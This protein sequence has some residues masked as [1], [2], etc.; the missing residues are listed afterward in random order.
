MVKEFL[1]GLSER[2]N[3][4]ATRG[5]AVAPCHEHARI[6]GEFRGPVDTDPPDSFSHAA[7]HSGRCVHA[8]SYFEHARCEEPSIAVLRKKSIQRYAIFFLADDNRARIGIIPAALL[9]C[10]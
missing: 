10:P 3:R 9:P 2:E 4:L 8:G 6:H 5:A 1:R 7:V